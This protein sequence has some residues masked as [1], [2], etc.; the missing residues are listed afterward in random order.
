MNSGNALPEPPSSPAGWYPD[1][2]QPET[3]RYW[4]GTAWTEQRAPLAKKSDEDLT[5]GVL[6]G[7]AIPIAGFLY[8]VWMLLK[9]NGNGGWVILLSF[10]AT[11]VWAFVLVFLFGVADGLSG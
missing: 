7:L 8:G 4:D 5:F 11:V 2:G 3:Q 9:G 10:I 6:L 1:P